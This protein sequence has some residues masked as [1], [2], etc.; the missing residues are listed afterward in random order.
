[1][2]GLFADSS[3]TLQPVLEQPDAFSVVVPSV[4]MLAVGALSG[5]SWTCRVRPLVAL[6]C[7]EDDVNSVVFTVHRPVCR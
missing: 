5:V 1:M 6:G 3:F 4:L 2:V 7:C